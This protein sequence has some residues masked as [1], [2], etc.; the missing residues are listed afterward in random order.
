MTI[1]LSRKQFTSVSSNY[2]ATLNEETKNA[3]RKLEGDKREL[4]TE[5]EYLKKRVDELEQLGKKSRRNT[6]Y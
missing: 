4:K 1:V 5:N 6:K 3:I 2:T